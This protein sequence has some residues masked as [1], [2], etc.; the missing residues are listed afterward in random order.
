M[1]QDKSHRENQMTH[2]EKMALTAYKQVDKECPTLAQF[3]QVLDR[4]A[5]NEK[6]VK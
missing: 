6:A 1:I 4:I 2:H 5:A 3:Q